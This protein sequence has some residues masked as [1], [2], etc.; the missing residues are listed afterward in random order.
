MTPFSAGEPTT[1]YHAFKEAAIAA[2]YA[3][4]AACNGT[5]M[6]LADDRSVNRPKEDP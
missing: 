6:R 2:R 5:V 3:L 4:L 1:G